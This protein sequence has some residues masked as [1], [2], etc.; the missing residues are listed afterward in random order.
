MLS[1]EPV[2]GETP[3][4]CWTVA[5]GNSYNDAERCIAAGYDNGDV[6]IFDLRTNTLRWDTNVRNGVCH[7]QFV[8]ASVVFIEKL[9]GSEGHQD[10]QAR[11][12]G[13]GPQIDL[14]FTQGVHIGVDPCG[15]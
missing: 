1:L 12:R 9:G 11:G 5:F 6:K 14:S 3:A 4:D 13:H 10:E 7:L 2:E 8:G 15:L